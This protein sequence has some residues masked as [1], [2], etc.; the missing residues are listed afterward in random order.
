MNPLPKRVA[1][2][3][4]HSRKG[5]SGALNTDGVTER[6]FNRQ[7]GKELCAALQRKGLFVTLFDDYPVN[8]YSAAMSWVG[9]QCK[10]VKADVAIELHFNSAGPFAKGH[11]WLYWHRSVKGKQ[12]AESFDRSFR[13]HFPAAV[14]R[15]AKPCGL[16]NRGSLFLRLTPCPSVILEPFF[17]SSKEETAFYTANRSKLVEAY[18]DA[19]VAALGRQQ[20]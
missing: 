13:K 3:I 7:V 2:C 4:G 1:V 11:E 14:A 17:G 20:S 19:L 6:A 18:A 10:L 5:D 9:A 15:G 12:L 16:D 8:G